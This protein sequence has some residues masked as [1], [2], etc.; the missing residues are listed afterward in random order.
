LQPCG[1]LKNYNLEDVYFL[2]LPFL[3]GGF[4][5]S[6]VVAVLV[7]VAGFSAVFSFAAELASTARWEL[8]KLSETLLAICRNVSSNT[9]WLA[10][11]SFPDAVTGSANKEM[12]LIII[13]L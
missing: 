10:S 12:I 6:G 9:S 4:E 5:L 3:L 7:S 2:F 1:F 8:F 11:T 13:S